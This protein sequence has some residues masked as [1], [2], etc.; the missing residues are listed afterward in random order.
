ML[1][2]L[3]AQDRA[4]LGV[5]I[6]G[7]ADVASQVASLDELSQHCLFQSDRILIQTEPECDHRVDQALG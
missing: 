7:A 5:E 3:A 6:A 1:L 2:A 4:S